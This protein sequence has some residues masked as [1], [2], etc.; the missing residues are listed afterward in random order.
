M[1]YNCN[2]HFT[3]R[4]RLSKRFYSHNSCHASSHVHDELLILNLKNVKNSKPTTRMRKM[5]SIFTFWNNSN[6]GIIKIWKIKIKL[7]SIF[8]NKSN[9]SC[10]K[11]QTRSHVDNWLWHC[12]IFNR[13]EKSCLL[14]YLVIWFVL[15]N[16][17]NQFQFILL[18]GWK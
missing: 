7:L 11:L 8:S 16:N 12:H 17:V 6:I 18:C 4:L 10:W 14:I 2:T 15:F 9:E 3:G 13:L 1:M 5:N